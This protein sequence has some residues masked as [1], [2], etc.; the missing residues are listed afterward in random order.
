[1]KSIARKITSG[2][3]CRGLC[4]I[5]L[6]GILAILIY[7]IVKPS[8]ASGTPEGQRPSSSD[9]ESTLSFMW[10]SPICK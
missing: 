5:V 9:P 8:K 1:M 7:I 6:M 4:I 10:Y 3:I 2:K